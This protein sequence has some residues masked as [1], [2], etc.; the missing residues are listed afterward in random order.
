[1]AND[2]LITLPQ[3][4]YSIQEAAA[5]IGKSD[6]TVR[7]YIKDG[8]FP[9]VEMVSGDK[10]DEYRI[11]ATDLGKLVKEKGL[12]INLDQSHDQ[13]EPAPNKLVSD[14]IEAREEIGLLTGQ[15]KSLTNDT[16]RITRERDQA[17]S[18]LENEEA[19]HA[20]TEEARIEIEKKQAVAEARVEE[21]RTQLEKAEK[22]R[23]EIAQ[24]RDSLGDKYSETA[25]SLSEASTDLEHAKNDAQTV[26]GERDEL[27]AKLAN[28][29]ASMGWWTRRRYS[30]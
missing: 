7:K 5:L 26:A 24:E 21:L 22:L 6:Q 15:I 3:E 17:R 12:V 11:P 16:E 2:S 19:G 30:K 10:G 1:M 18:D 8:K 23:A 29:E 13:S 14:L 9:G 28:A 20:Q 27:A 4:G 25:K